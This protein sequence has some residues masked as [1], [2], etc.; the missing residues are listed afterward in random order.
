MKVLTR[1]ETYKFV[2]WA[3]SEVFWWP[4]LLIEKI[5]INL[6]HAEHSLVLR[7]SFGTPGRCDSSVLKDLNQRF[8][9][10]KGLVSSCTVKMHRK[11][12]TALGGIEGELNDC[13]TCWDFLMERKHFSNWNKG[14]WCCQLCWEL[15]ILT[16]TTFHYS[17]CWSSEAVLEKSEIA[18]GAFQD[19]RWWNTQDLDE[20]NSRKITTSP[21]RGNHLFSEILLSPACILPK[22]LSSEHCHLFHLSVLLFEGSPSV[23]FS[24]SVVSIL[25]DL[26][27][28]STPGLPVHH[29]L[30]EFTQTHVHR[31]GDAIQPSHPLQSPSPPAFNLFQQLGLFQ[32][33][34]SS[35]QGAEV[36]ELQHQSFQLIFRVD[37]L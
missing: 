34:S 25:C 3:P 33:I 10:N 27:D 21:G 14:L 32:W 9:A 31:F 26:M 37:F 18:K 29:Q 8:C 15:L 1:M 17:S 11:G 13:L 36:L 24:C 16:L 5:R 12:K 22:A 23:Q 19:L 28:C 30:P 4:S 6:V 35:H 7:Y 2:L 20:V